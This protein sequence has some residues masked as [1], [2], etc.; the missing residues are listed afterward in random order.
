MKPL[1]EFYDPADMTICVPASTLA[2]DLDRRLAA[3]GLRFPLGVAARMPMGD[4][5]LNHRWVATS[6]RFGSVAD[7]VLGMTW[8]LPGGKPVQ[9][10]SRVV[11]NVAGFDM[12]RFLCQSRGRLGSPQLMVLRLRPRGERWEGV[13]ADGPL[14]ALQALQDKIL[15]SSWAHAIDACLLVV[16]PEKPFLWTPFNADQAQAGLIQAWLQTSAADLGLSSLC[17]RPHLPDTLDDYKVEIQ[18]LPSRGA[19]LAESLVKEFGG[20]SLSMG[21]LGL[22]EYAPPDINDAGLARRLLDLRVQLA[23]LGGHVLAP[24]LPTPQPGPGGGWEK[25]IAQAWEALP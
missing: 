25:Q 23:P 20:R 10:G 3:D 9:L 18:T 12:I 21:G 17:R 13:Q 2:G 14:A 24:G 1:E 7:N 22:V 8:T 16:R 11:K 6:L 4:L 19:A 5:Y 15:H